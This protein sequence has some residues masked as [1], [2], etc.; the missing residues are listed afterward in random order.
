[1]QREPLHGAPTPTNMLLL[2]SVYFVAWVIYGVSGVILTNTLEIQTTQSGF[3]IASGFVVSWL[4]GFLS[5]L[6][7][8]G[9]G[10]REATLVLLLQPSVPAPQAIALALFA[11]ATWTII[12][13]SGV[14]IGLLV[15]RGR[16]GMWKN[17]Y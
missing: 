6:T 3:V 2:L 11:R 16:F 1:M 13:I 9:L 4:V 15:G 8:G 7:P 12:E 17:A 14:G 5:M 10:V